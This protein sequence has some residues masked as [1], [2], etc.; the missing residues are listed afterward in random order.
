MEY[1]LNWLPLLCQVFFQCVSTKN[2]RENHLASSL[3][4][5]KTKKRTLV[6]PVCPTRKKIS[7]TILTV[8]RHNKNDPISRA[9]SLRAERIA[10]WFSMW[11]LH[12]VF[13][14]FTK[15]SIVLE[16]FFAVWMSSQQNANTFYCGCWLFLFNKGRRKSMFS[17]RKKLISAN[18]ACR[19]ALVC[20]L[21]GVCRDITPGTL[22]RSESISRSGWLPKLAAKLFCHWP[23]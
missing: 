22:P 2:C 11:L 1:H 23:V 18:T 21:A 8:W 9:A 6:S 13:S 16:N 20:S 10:H 12:A 17:S 14:W 19:W 4:I 15:L 3:S 7:E 5:F